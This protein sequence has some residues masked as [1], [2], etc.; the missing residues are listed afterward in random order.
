MLIWLPIYNDNDHLLTRT[1]VI[2]GECR[3]VACFPLHCQAWH[4]KAGKGICFK[5]FKEHF[6]SQASPS[7]FCGSRFLQSWSSVTQH[8]HLAADTTSI[9]AEGHLCGCHWFQYIS[10]KNELYIWLLEQGTGFND[11]KKKSENKIYLYIV[12]VSHELEAWQRRR[13]KL[14]YSLWN[15]RASENR[16]HREL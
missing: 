2:M 4:L 5:P 8:H 7:H 1:A 6:R 11:L 3:S 13:P 12:S 9:A 10:V 16:I 15:F 14:L